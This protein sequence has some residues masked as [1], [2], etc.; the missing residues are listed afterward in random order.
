MFIDMAGVSM[1]SLHKG[2]HMFGVHV[3]VEA[4]AQVGDVA[5]GPKALQ[6]FLHQLPDLLL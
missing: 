5:L 4:V 6:H 1:H 2:S 3:W